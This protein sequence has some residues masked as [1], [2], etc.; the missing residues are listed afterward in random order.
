MLRRSFIQNTGMATTLALS[1]SWINFLR[2]SNNM[3]TL[4]R[5]VG[6]YTEKGGTIGWLVQPANTVIVDSQF[7]PQARNLIDEISKEPYFEIR[8]LINTHHH[9]DHTSGNIEFK[10]LANNVLA[11]ENSRINQM[12]SAKRN[13][14]ESEQLYP[15]MTFTERWQ[16]KI[17]DEIVDIQYWGPAHTNG[18]SIIHFQ[19]ANVVHVG[20][21][22]FNRRYPYI[23]KTAGARIDNWIE[24]LQQLQ[25]YF[26]DDA[27][28]IFGHAR[29]GYEVT[30]GKEDIAAFADYLTALLEY[31]SAQ[32][33]SGNSKEDILATKEIP[34]APQWQGDGIERSLN[35]ALEELG[36]E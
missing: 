9:G 14:A 20:D 15:D 22:M 27:I 36:A 17:G 1:P 35:A 5:N 24:I 12:I 4:R 26:D 6:I 25:A 33:K 18:D 10:G 13:N 7:R 19:H 34:G 16:E 21:L 2:Y 3:K 8:Y 23:D 32:L 30:G 11:H 29:E 28:F 31:V